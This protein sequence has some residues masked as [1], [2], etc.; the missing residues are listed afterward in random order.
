MIKKVWPIQRKRGVASEVT[1]DPNG[2]IPVHLKN[3][4]CNYQSCVDL[5]YL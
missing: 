5:P 3:G 1:T 2:V 4:A